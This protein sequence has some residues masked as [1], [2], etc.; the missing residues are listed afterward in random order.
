MM[1]T[2]A[3]FAFMGVGKALGG[4]LIDKI[5][6]RKT[7]YIS[8]LGAIPFLLSGNE[9]MMVSLVGVMFFSMTMA[10]TLA[11]LV[12]TY[13]DN[14]GVAFGFTTVGLAIGAMPIFFFRITDL[15][16]NDIII[17]I[18]SIMCLYILLKVTKKEV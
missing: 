13:R 5:G 3:L 6:I 11:I 16:L 8:M 10:I 17:V 2:V 9:L 18:M 1:Q 15:L 7:I 4:I 12:S 14:P